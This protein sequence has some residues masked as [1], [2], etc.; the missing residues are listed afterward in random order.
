MLKFFRKNKMD[1][2]EPE[3]QETKSDDSEEKLLRIR[4]NG[5]LIDQFRIRE[6]VERDEF[7]ELAKVVIHIYIPNP[8]SKT[9]GE[10]YYRLLSM[11]QGLVV[12]ENITYIQLISKDQQYH[13][14]LSTS[15]NTKFKMILS[16]DDEKYFYPEI[17]Q[18]NYD[19]L[20]FKINCS[21]EFC[22]Y[23]EVDC[24]Y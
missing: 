20:R 4:V 11:T 15:D 22:K 14:R 10:E 1:F 19:E 6:L 9:P 8:F 16:E 12:P 21:C 7:G 13:F 23:P 3:N 2:E 18:N 17:K 24:K 5:E